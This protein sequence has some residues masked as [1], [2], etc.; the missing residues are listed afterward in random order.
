MSTLDGNRD[1]RSNIH[2]RTDSK[3]FHCRGRNSDSEVNHN[4]LN[5]TECKFTEQ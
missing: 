5:S 2:E 1:S 4:E 3:Q